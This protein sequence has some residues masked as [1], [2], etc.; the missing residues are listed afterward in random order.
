M[1]CGRWTKQS[2]AVRILSLCRHHPAGRNGT[3]NCRPSLV[4]APS[5]NRCWHYLT[6]THLRA[7]HRSAQFALR[8]VLKSLSVDARVIHA[9]FRPLHYPIGWRRQRLQVDKAGRRQYLNPLHKLRTQFVRGGIVLEPGR[10]VR[11]RSSAVKFG[12]TVSSIS[13]SRNAAFILSKAKWVYTR[14]C[15]SA[16]ERGCLKARAR[17]NWNLHPSRRLPK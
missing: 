13:F 15:L 7:W 17:P 8:I 12:R 5:K 9:A 10:I 14:E 11:I 3:P 1:A 2:G 4:T 6:Q 16:T